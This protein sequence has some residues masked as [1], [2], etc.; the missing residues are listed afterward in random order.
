MAFTYYMWNITTYKIRSFLPLKSYHEKFL[1]EF[2]RSSKPWL[3][4]LSIAWKSRIG[5]RGY[6]RYLFSVVANVCVIRSLTRSGCGWFLLRQH[7]PSS[8]KSPTLYDCKPS[9]NQTCQFWTKKKQTQTRSIGIIMITF[10]AHTCQSGHTR[11]RPTSIFTGE[12]SLFAIYRQGT[13]PAFNPN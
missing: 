13:K 10:K 7:E 5:T 4:A 2:Q 12:P 9:S 1:A 8:H 11:V 6:T 3:A